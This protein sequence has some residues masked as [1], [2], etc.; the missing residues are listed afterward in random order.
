M[1]R[2]IARE[3]KTG[4]DV[5]STIILFSVNAEKETDAPLRIIRIVPGNYLGNMLGVYVPGQ[6][7][8]N[9]KTKKLSSQPAE[10]G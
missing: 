9:K 4:D 10:S 7:R 1:F 3:F 5:M 6:L 2:W 8:I